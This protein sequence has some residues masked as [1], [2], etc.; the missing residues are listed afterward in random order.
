MATV[1]YFAFVSESSRRAALTDR[2]L[3]FNGMPDAYVT[4]RYPAR[5]LF[6]YEMPVSSQRCISI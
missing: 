3:L 6:A 5:I 4:E 1:R 2:A